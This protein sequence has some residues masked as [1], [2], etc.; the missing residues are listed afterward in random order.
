MKHL[1]EYW[2]IEGEEAHQNFEELLVFLEEM[3][4]FV[5][6]K[7]AAERR[8]ELE[9]LGRSPEDLLKVKPPFPRMNYAD[10]LKKLNAK[11]RKLKWGDD[12]GTED[13]ELLTADLDKP[14][15]LTHFPKEAKAF[16]MKEN[17]D[18]KTVNAV[19][20]LAPK[21]FGE[22]V[23]GSERET[24][25]NVLIAKLKAQKAD[26]KNYEW[27]L[28]LRRYGSVQHSGFGLGTERFVRWVCGLEHIRDAIPFPRVI[29]RAY[30]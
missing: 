10:A 3:I 27:Y 6:N 16:Y 28:D 4:S 17:E 20:I 14:L 2:H 8:K 15:L 13:E 19:D 18:G 25:V 9:V 21:G 1:A 30:P 11:G 24:D 7:I 29:N 12:F 5:C 22:L 23:G 26:L